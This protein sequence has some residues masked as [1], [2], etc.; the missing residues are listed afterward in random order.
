MIFLFNANDINYSGYYGLDIE[1]RI[2]RCNLLQSVE[3][4]LTIY[5]G[6]IITTPYVKN[7][8]QL[9]ELLNRMLID[10]EQL[11]I[12]KDIL[13]YVFTYECVFAWSIR[14]ISDEL[15]LKL[16]DTLWMDTGYLGMLK[17]NDDNIIHRFLF[18][19]FLVKKYMLCNYEVKIIA[20]ILSENEYRG[21]I[22]YLRKMGFQKVT[23][24]GDTNE[25][26]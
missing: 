25:L 2:W 8:N 13:R 10:T 17:M 14:G 24:T 15:S 11:Y 1:R 18:K 26:Y 19:D 4:E 12:K 7:V 23:L 21:T 16:H 3:N 20:D 5:Q 9:Q 6:D 22:D